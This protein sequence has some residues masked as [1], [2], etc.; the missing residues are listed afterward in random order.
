MKYDSLDCLTAT[1]WDLYARI[2]ANQPAAGLVP[3][4]SSF[5]SPRVACYL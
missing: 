1:L 5:F 3:P 4:A 2:S